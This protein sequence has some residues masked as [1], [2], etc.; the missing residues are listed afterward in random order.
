MISEIQMLR[1]APAG[2]KGPMRLF[3]FVWGFS[4][5][6]LLAVFAYASWMHVTGRMVYL[7]AQIAFIG[8]LL[9]VLVGAAAVRCIKAVTAKTGLQ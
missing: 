6:I 5:L 2:V 1:K 3:L 8:L 9:L 7:P 4:L